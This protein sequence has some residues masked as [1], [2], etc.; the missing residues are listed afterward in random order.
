MLLTRCTLLFV[1]GFAVGA[2][3]CGSVSDGAPDAGAGAGDDAAVSADL[4]IATAELPDGNVDEAY[5]V[6]LEA[7]GGEP[8]YAWSASGLPPGLAMDEDGSLTGT[9][10]EAGDYDPE[11]TV[12]DDAGAT[13]EASLALQIRNDPV[14]QT[15]E[16][17]ALHVFERYQA[18]IEVRGGEPPFEFE[19]SDLPPGLVIDSESGTIENDFFS[20]AVGEATPREVSITVTDDAGATASA[21]LSLE[22]VGIDQFATGSHHVCAIDDEGA[23]WCWGSNSFRQLGTEE[24]VQT[25]RLPLRVQ[26]EHV[27]VSIAGGFSHTCAIDDAG[28]TWCW[29]R[30]NDGQLGNDDSG[31]SPEP[32]PVEVHDPVGV[33][34][35]VSFAA[36]F[37]G[38]SHTCAIGDDSRVYC[39]GRNQ[40]G[41]LGDGHSGT[42]RPVPGPV[43]FHGEYTI[44]ELSPGSAH[45][46]AAD[47]NGLAFCWGRN[48]EG[49]LGNGDEDERDVAWPVSGDHDF[50]VLSAGTRHTCGI[51]DAGAAHCWGSGFSGQLGN[52]A[53]GSDAGELEPKLVLGGRAFSDLATGG[54]HSCGI[55]ADESIWCWGRNNQGQI[56]ND[57]PGND[58]S[59]VPEPIDSDRHFVAIDAGEGFTCG[60]S[61]ERVLWCWGSNQSGQLGN[62]SSDNFRAVPVLPHPGD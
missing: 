52:G 56:G 50:E 11:F 44:T 3:A 5:E 54:F 33:A 25:S 31:D 60:L 30:N 27:F 58:N 36:V 10:T 55:T 34:D 13:E 37:A 16:L 46:C 22:T 57:D 7:S 2:A 48:N 19:A 8:P 45:A 38:E 4:A 18:E 17:P 28:Q 42:N 41:Q 47:E 14:I 62:D 21:E 35:D 39:W 51:D 29:G 6:S 53:D 32:A 12:T 61:T 59:V 1:T 43:A 40:D 23:A 15:A 26:G 49:Q 9:P 24:S 20:P